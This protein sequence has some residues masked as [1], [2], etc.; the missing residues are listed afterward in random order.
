MLEIVLHD[1]ASWRAHLLPMA[2]TRPVGA[3]RI[4]VLTLR[5]KWQLFLEAP[6]R[7][8]TEPYLQE[9]FHAPGTASVY[10]VIRANICPT[11]RLVEVLSILPEESLLVKDGEWVAYKVKDWVAEPDRTALK[12]YNFGEELPRVQFLEDIY[13][14]NAD[15]LLL[16]FEVLTKDKISARLHASNT[17][18]GDKLFVGSNVQA[19]CCT[20]NT[21]DGPVYLADDVI[22]EEGCHL[23]GPIAIGKGA[24]VK[25]G[26]RLYPNVSVGPYCT[27]GGEVNN[28]VMWDN[29]GKG[30]D[31]YLGC[32]VIGEG[33]NIGAGTSNS[34]LQN[35]WQPITLYDYGQKDQRKTNRL[36]VGMFMGDFGMCGINSSVTT[37]HIMGV[38][39]Q[40]AMSTIVPKFVS[41]FSWITDA[42]HEIYVWKKFEQMLK[43]RAAVRKE[44]VKEA[45]I[46]IL[47]EVYRLTRQ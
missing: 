38:G 21:L 43:A 31:G 19:Y 35:N 47:W 14:Q 30:H 28:T 17:V 8:H 24:R 16:D 10:L 2:F 34:N 27:I 6:V 15:Q 25:M 12:L 33:C 41:D 9:K 3:F 5:E 29:S 4:G 42:K 45:D 44:Y 40:V 13:L 11:P 20:F 39:A 26:S 36:K 37:G 22:L 46:R 1:R 32:S 23:K 7:F 18:L